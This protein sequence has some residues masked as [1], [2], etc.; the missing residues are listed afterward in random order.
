[1]VPSENY[2]TD[3][4]EKFPMDSEFSR[5]KKQLFYCPRKTTSCRK[6]RNPEERYGLTP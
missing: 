3:L 2:L 6:E 4:L 1:M 5:M